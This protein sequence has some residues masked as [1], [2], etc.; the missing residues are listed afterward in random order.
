MNKQNPPPQEW[1]FE[2]PIG[3]ILKDIYTF[4]EELLANPPRLIRLYAER[5]QAN[6][7]LSGLTD[8]QEGTVLEMTFSCRPVKEGAI[9]PN[10]PEEQVKTFSTR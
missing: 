4:S 2:T 6:W 5:V 1:T 7:A 8:G 10:L 9:K 3:D